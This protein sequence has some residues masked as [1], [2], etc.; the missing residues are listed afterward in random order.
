VLKN[1]EILS[2]DTCSGRS[3]S[4]VIWNANPSVSKEKKEDLKKIDLKESSNGDDDN[5]EDEYESDTEVETREENVLII[6]QMKW[7]APQNKV[8]N[9][10][11]GC[12]FLLLS[13]RIRSIVVGLTPAGPHGKFLVFL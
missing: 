2:L 12:F 9:N 13:S 6:E 10:S 5:I 1:G 3:L 8:T 11:E 4:R 7:L